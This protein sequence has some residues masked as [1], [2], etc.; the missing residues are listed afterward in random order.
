MDKDQYIAKKKEKKRNK[1]QAYAALVFPSNNP[2]SY[3]EN[4]EAIYA[5]FLERGEIDGK[6]FQFPINFGPNNPATDLQ[7]A[8]AILYARGTSENNYVP[9]L[10][11]EKNV[12]LDIFVESN[13]EGTPNVK[14]S[15]YNLWAKV[16]AVLDKMQANKMKSLTLRL[17]NK[18]GQAIDE[19]GEALVRLPEQSLQ[20]RRQN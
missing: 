20:L 9:Q 11:A 15:G 19:G 13:D 7:N 16:L 17:F 2:N 12:T 14:N 10:Y 5:K 8:E 18:K 6:T 4:K 3:L 1:N